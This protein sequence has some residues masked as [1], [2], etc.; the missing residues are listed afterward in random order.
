MVGRHAVEPVGRREQVPRVATAAA[1]PGEAGG[2]AVTFHDERDLAGRIGERDGNAGE[3]AHDKIIQA[4]AERAG[5]IHQRINA[6]G[7]QQTIEAID[8]E[9]VRAGDGEVAGDDEQVIRFRHT[10]GVVGQIEIIQRASVQREV[11]RDR[12]RAG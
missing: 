12:E 7:R 9:G 4:A 10:A 2:C 1:G 3:A 6:A 8:D 11:V 5:I